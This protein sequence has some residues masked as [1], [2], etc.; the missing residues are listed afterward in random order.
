MEGEIKV[1]QVG[2]QLEGAKEVVRM[3]V[4]ENG[5]NAVFIDAEPIDDP[6][7]FGMMVVDILKHGAMGFVHSKGMDPQQA[8]EGIMQ[9]LASEI[10]RTNEAAE[11]SMN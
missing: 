8:F 3:W 1:E 7:E 5:P 6:R 9:G 4:S 2:A 10:K 11:R